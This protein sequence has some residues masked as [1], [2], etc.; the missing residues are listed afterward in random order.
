MLIRNVSGAISSIRV[1]I[2]SS[3]VF[4]RTPAVFQVSLSRCHYGSVTTRRSVTADSGGPRDSWALT[5]TRLEARARPLE[6]RRCSNK[7]HRFYRGDAA[8]LQVGP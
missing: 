3:C 7:E 5:G 2:G 8:A 6:H 1:D 4:R